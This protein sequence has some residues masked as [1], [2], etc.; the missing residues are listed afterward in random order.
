MYASR[1]CLAEAMLTFVVL[2]ADTCY[3][4]SGAGVRADW[5]YEA[6]QVHGTIKMYSRDWI[7]GFELSVTIMTGSGWR[8]DELERRCLC[9][10]EARVSVVERSSAM[11]DEMLF[12]DWWPGA[13]S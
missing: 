1:I 6:D 9:I 8:T 12:K 7:A 3:G 13:A 11:K 10:A 4:K 5:R 2:L